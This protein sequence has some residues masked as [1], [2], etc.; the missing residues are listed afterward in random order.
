MI[1]NL[2]LVATRPDA[3]APAEVETSCRF[4]VYRNRLEDEQDIYIGKRHDVL[5]RAGESWL[6]VR[7]EVLL[8]QNVL[9][10]KNLSVFF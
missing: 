5:R 3:E 4:L 7:R 1:A 10:A 2:R 6:I 9:L 8:D